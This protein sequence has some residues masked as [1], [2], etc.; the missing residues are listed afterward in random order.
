[1]TGSS[2]NRKSTCAGAS[3]RVWERVCS[4]GAMRGEAL[5]VPLRRDPRRARGDELVERQGPDVV[6]VERG[7]LLEV[8][9]RR[10]VGHVG[11]P[12]LALDDVPRDDLGVA[13][14]RPAERHQ[15]VHHRRGEVALVAVA[16]E[17]HLVAPLRQ[18]LAALVD[19]HR[20]VRPDRHLVAERLPQ[21]LL[22]GRV[23]EVLVAADD[24]GDPHLDVV[25]DV[26]QHED[27]GAVG[28]QQDEVLDRLVGELDV[29]ADDVVDDGRPVG[30]A[31]AQH[32]PRPRAEPAVARV[33]VVALPAGRLGALLHLLAGEVAVVRPPVL[34]QPLGCGDVGRRRWRSGS[35]DPRTPGRRRRC[36]ARPGH[37]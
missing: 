19:E 16:L 21:Q 26:G 17:G 24:V 18:L 2:R 29:A 36:P 34:V 13:L 37:R 14:R 20:H 25:D 23:R 32:P 6:A 11:E 27:R 30:D 35:T 33:P 4:S 28:A 3:A 15:V 8:E 31:E 10:R 5:A 1:M 22:L 7:E 12:E 9:E